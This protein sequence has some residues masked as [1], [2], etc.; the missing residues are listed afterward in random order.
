MDEDIRRS[1]PPGIARNVSKL[2]AP[3]AVQPSWGRVLA[4]TVKVSVSRLRSTGSGQQRTS[5]Q[6][7]G[8]RFRWYLGAVVVALAVV[9]VAVMQF[10]GV[11]AGAVA[12]AHSAAGPVAGS[13][14]VGDTSS[15]IAAVRAQAAA[16]VAG[17]V[18]AGAIVACDSAMCA[19]LQAQGVT[20][21]RLI[22]LPSGTADP[23]G[24]TVVVASTRARSQLTDRVA[25][26]VIA[27]FGSGN[28][29][30]EVRAT[31]LGG[32]AAY[33]SAL[34][35]DLAA[36]ESAGSQLLR[37]SRIQFTAQAS[38]EL[39]AGEVDSRLLVTLA[40]LSSQYSFRV[41]AFSDASPGVQAPFREVTITSG[42][43]GRGASQLAAALALVKSQDPP[44]MP[45]HATIA[46]LASAP[47]ALYIEFAAPSP[48]GLLTPVLL[49]HPQREAA[50]KT[51]STSAS[52][53]A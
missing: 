7:G 3:V 33:Q 8:K 49:V 53:G 21:G 15:G 52:R 47:T 2:T 35:A 9:A 44:Y 40:G 25:P 28:A 37:D 22:L 16:W 10:T 19:A 32:A 26:A 50:P 41:A 27:S 6:P 29:Q 13:D 5:G 38:A 17:Q 18:S 46:R 12:P 43:G 42:G 36:R 1:A 45:D 24:A 48:L 20:A 31:E 4:T 23:D 11:F 39:R 34:R 51:F 30:I 14:R